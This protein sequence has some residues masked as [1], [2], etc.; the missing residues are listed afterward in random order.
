MQ[1]QI[2]LNARKNMES[3]QFLEIC[4]CFEYFRHFCI[5]RIFI[6]YLN[7]ISQKFANIYSLIIASKIYSFKDEYILGVG[8]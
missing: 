4:Y 1:I 8:E 7:L 5:L 6:L 3:K 2:F